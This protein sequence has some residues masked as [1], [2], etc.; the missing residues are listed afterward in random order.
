MNLK[1]IGKEAHEININNG[2]EVFTP[3]HWPTNGSREKV[4]FLGTHMTLVHEEVS[5]AFR[6]VRKNDRANFEEEL[7]DVIIRVTSI[8]Y[9]LGADLDAVVAAKMEKNRARGLHHGGR[10]V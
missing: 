2:W 6:G 1:E 5:E 3:D 4:N 8:A 10:L 7:A 9:G